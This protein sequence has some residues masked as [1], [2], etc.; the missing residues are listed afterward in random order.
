M[1][2][3]SD[4]I[5]AA[6]TYTCWAVYA[7]TGAGGAHLNGFAEQVAGDGIV[8]R[9]YYDLSAMRADA[10]LMAWFYGPDPVALQAAART[11]RE[12]LE[13]AARPVWS[14]VGV[15]RPAEFNRRHVPAFLAG[16]EPEAW[17]TVYPFVRSLEWYLLPEP[18]RAEMLRE[19]GEMGREYPHVL[20]NTV[21]AFALGDYEWIIALEAPELVDLV[22]LMRRLRYSQARRH[23]RLEVPFYT[24]RRIDAIEAGNLLR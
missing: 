2:N 1:P 24:G 10:D 14:G 6:I 23:V 12:R 8:T 7:R 4:A 19:H 3:L 5:N 16:H 9:G 20:A 17:L 15:H 13:P 22:D 21:S 18:E 11:L